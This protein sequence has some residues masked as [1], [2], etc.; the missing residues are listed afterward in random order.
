MQTIQIKDKKFTISISES[1]IQ[2]AVMEVAKKLNNDLWDKNPLFICVLNGAFMFAADLLRNF[3]FPCEITFVKYS[4]YSGLKT[5]GA[6]HEHIGLDKC[7]EGRSVVI[8]EDIVDTGLTMKSITEMLKSNGAA[9]VRI[10]TLLQKPD[11]LEHSIAV[12]Y[13]ALNIPNDFVVGYGLDYDGQGR[14][15]KEIYTLAE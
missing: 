14:N 2:T 3:T 11:A 12:D 15:L 5:T 8:I 6:I 9:D 1:E 7:I 13:V 4:S 10:A